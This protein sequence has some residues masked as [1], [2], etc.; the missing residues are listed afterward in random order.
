MKGTLSK[1]HDN[2]IRQMDRLATIDAYD[3]D[4]IKAECQRS[5]AMG[6]LTNAV[7]SNVRLGIEIMKLKRE[8]KEGEPEHELITQIGGDME[9]KKI[10][11]DENQPS[12]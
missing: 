2:L 11:K 3:E 6:K 8:K 10:S 1:I 5:H 7:A 12:A 9:P 4:A